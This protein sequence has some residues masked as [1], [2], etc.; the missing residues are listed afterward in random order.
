MMVIRAAGGLLKR[1]FPVLQENLPACY[2][3]VR[4]EQARFYLRLA[5]C[6]ARLFGDLGSDVCRREIFRFDR[7]AVPTSPC[8]QGEQILRLRV[9]YV[10]D[11]RYSGAVQFQE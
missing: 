5:A 6:F 4:Q 9:M 2:R 7:L 3:V 11:F 8:A 1:V 10:D